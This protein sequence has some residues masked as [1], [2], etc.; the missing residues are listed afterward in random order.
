MRTEHWQP[1]SAH[2]EDRTADTLE[3]S[4]Y[5]AEAI[6][7]IRRMQQTGATKHNP[8]W[9]S[10]LVDKLERRHKRLALKLNT[11]KAQRGMLPGGRQ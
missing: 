9:A 3:D 6:A 4:E 5:I 2:I 11:L 1:E 8:E 7:F 10:E